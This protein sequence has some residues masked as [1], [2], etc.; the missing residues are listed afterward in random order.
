M[1][2]IS[3][4]PDSSSL[5]TPF[6]ALLQNKYEVGAGKQQQQ[7]PTFLT[8]FFLMLSTANTCSPIAESSIQG[9]RRRWRRQR[10]LA[11]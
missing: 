7:Q 4:L 5:K 2:E 9:G 3:R 6:I 1:G 8:R 11:D 10:L